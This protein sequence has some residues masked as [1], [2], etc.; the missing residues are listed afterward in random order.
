MKPVRRGLPEIN[1]R[2]REIERGMKPCFERGVRAL[3]PWKPFLVQQ[4]TTLFVVDGCRGA[5]S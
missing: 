4:I 5:L 3:F 2:I 1:K